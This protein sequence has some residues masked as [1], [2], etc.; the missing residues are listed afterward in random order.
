MYAGAPDAACGMTEG[1]MSGQGNGAVMRVLTLGAAVIFGTAAARAESVDALYEKAKLEKTVAL[2]GAGPSDPFKRWIADFEKSYPGVNVAFTG[3]LS[4]ALDKKIDQQLAAKTMEA[5][6]GI[7]QTMQDFVRWK[8]AG[9]LMR[10]KPDG[11]DAIDPAFKDE[12]GAFT[13]VSVN[14]ITYAWNTQSVD[15]ADVP[16]SAL[17]FLKPMFRGKLITTDPTDDDAGFMA[18]YAIIKKYGWDYMTKYIAQRPRFTRLG[19]AVV[20]NAIAAGEMVATF[21][22]TSTTPLLVREGKPIRLALSRDDPTPLFLVAGA[23]FKDAPHPSAAKLFL[24]WY[25]A[26]QQQVRN[27]AFSARSDVAPPPGFQPLASYQLDRSFRALHSDP[28]QL[29]ELKQRLAGF[30]APR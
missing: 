10:F 23:I 17:D 8:Q 9:A 20:S 28:A 16:K 30:D 21:D 11:F 27:G 19:H 22:S 3:G 4:N 13:T 7:F 26:P 14:L 5:D 24:D 18:F 12:D 15:A 1:A 29:A 6:V 25:L 2:Y